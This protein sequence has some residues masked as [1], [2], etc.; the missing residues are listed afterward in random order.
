MAT[1]N[2]TKGLEKYDNNLSKFSRKRRFDE[3][4]ELNLMFGLS[5]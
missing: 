5:I 3:I 2:S 1:L 4:G